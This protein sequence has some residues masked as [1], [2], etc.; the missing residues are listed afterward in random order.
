MTVRPPRQSPNKSRAWCPGHKKE[1]IT[2]V[3]EDEMGPQIDA[4]LALAAL[5]MAARLEAERLHLRENLGSADGERR[6]RLAEAVHALRA[7][8]R[9]GGAGWGVPPFEGDVD[10]GVARLLGRLDEVEVGE[11]GG[12]VL[13]RV[14][15]AL[16]DLEG[17]A[18]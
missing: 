2:V 8:A 1:T 17:G 11:R 16:G 18:R 5:E 3:D 7:L 13:R 14:R 4:E 10:A 15:R 12:R 9:L 6:R